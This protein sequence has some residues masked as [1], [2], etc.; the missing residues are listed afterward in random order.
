MP[1][2]MGS[3]AAFI[4]YNNDGFQD[5]FFVNGRDWTDAEV[6]AYKNGKW[7]EKEIR[8]FK[9]RHGNHAYRAGM[10]RYIPARRP[11]NAPRR[12]LSQ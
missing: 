10:P 11:I 5:I 7:T 3:G 1:E 9:K 8:T 2:S 4:D 6:T 12:T